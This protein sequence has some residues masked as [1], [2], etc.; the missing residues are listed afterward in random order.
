MIKEGSR[1]G[2]FH[3]LSA[4]IFEAC[5]VDSYKWQ[6]STAWMKTSGHFRNYGRK[7]YCNQKASK[8]F[9][10]CWKMQLHTH[11]KFQPRRLYIILCDQTLLWWGFS[12]NPLAELLIH[13]LSKC[14][15]PLQIVFEH[16]QEV[17]IGIYGQVWSDDSFLIVLV[18]YQKLW[19]SS[20]QSDGDLH[21][22][23]E[24]FNVNFHKTAWGWIIVTFIISFK[25]IRCIRSTGLTS[26]F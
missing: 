23:N 8:W 18:V 4:C 22:I 25:S 17:A 5:Y 6:W 3:I 14:F 7:R 20:K 21:G 15:F 1:F 16:V 12:P 10:K 19:A 9:R 13:H 11:Y 26:E 2:L 24:C